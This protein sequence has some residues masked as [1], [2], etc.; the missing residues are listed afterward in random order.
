MYLA[1]L[2]VYCRFKA[3]LRLDQYFQSIGE[4]LANHWQHIGPMLADAAAQ[5]TFNRTA[6]RLQARIQD[7]RGEGPEFMSQQQR[8]VRVS[9]PKN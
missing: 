8:V 4:T 5:R 3:S 1:I 2:V 7:F 6:Q 9:L